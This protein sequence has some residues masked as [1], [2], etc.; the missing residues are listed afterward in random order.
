M[1]PIIL[2]IYFYI[3]LLFR[4]YAYEVEKSCEMN[5]SLGNGIA[6]FQGLSNVALNCKDL[7]FSLI[8]SFDLKSALLFRQFS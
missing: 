1:A 5:E 8:S 4:L 7:F 6:V 3:Y 2:Y